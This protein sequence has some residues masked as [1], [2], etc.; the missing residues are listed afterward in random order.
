[1]RGSGGF[2]AF[3]LGA[4]TLAGCGRSS[5]IGN[6]GSDCPP[7]AHCVPDMA[8]LDM[9]RDMSLDM[10]PD[11]MRDMR[12]M[13][14][15]MRGDMRDM[16]D[17]RGDMRGGDMRGGDMGNPECGVTIPCTDPRCESDPHCH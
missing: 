15:D 11:D 12:D 10:R 5:L 8:G 16:R 13:R 6:G 7:G 17:M 3:A 9:G 2:V 1:M 4:L 14:L